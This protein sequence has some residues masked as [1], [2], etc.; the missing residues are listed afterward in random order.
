MSGQKIL[1]TAALPYANGPLHFG[2]IAGAYL[3]ADCYARFERLV[4]NKVLYICGSDEYGVAITLSAEK[5]NRSPKEHID[6]FHKINKDFFKELQISFDHYSRTTNEEHAALAQEFFLDLYN[7]GYIEEKVENHL[8]SEKDDKF[9]A[10][11]YV[12][13]TCPKC[14][15]EKARGDECGSCGASYEATDLKNPVSAISKS[16][17]ILKPSKHWY[18]RFDK[19][20]DKLKKWISKK[21]WKS[22]VMKFALNY[23]D[24]LKPRAIT[25]DSTWGVPVPLKDTEGKVLYVWF[26]AP[27]GYISATKEYAKK[28]NNEKLFD[29]FWLSDDTT[30]VNFIGKDNIPFHAIFFPAMQMGQNKKYKIVDQLPANEFLLLEKK[31][32]S[33]SNNWYIDLEE[34]FKKFST[35]Q[36]RFYLASIMPETS[37]SDFSWKDFQKV[38]NSDLVGKFGNFIHR[39]LTFT[40]N[41]L[42]SKIPQHNNLSNED[43]E[44][45]KNVDDLVDLSKTAYKN[46][47]LRKASHII[48]E[49]ASLGNVYFDKK[50]PWKETPDLQA[51]TIYCCI[52]AI[53]S[54]CLI[55]NPIIPTS[56]EKIWKLL[57]NENGFNSEKGCENFWDIIKNDKL[58]NREQKIN[59]P[60]TLFNKIED[61]EIIYQMDKLNKSA[62]AIKETTPALAS[63][64]ELKNKIKYDDFDKLDFRVGLITNAHKIEKSNKLLKLEVDIGIEKRT[65]VSGIAKFV[66]IEE[67][68]GKKVIVLANIEKT[69]IMGVESNGMIIAAGDKQDFDIPYLENTNIGSIVN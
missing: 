6:I 17:L 20:K 1:I 26:D 24:D 33:K 22:N 16:P 52:Y 58:D 49:L 40:K 36:L 9:L 12:E 25:R 65:I 2:H 3:P 13:G 62:E 51:N 38:C 11:R 15:F 67:L 14:G 68:L 4:G 35:D 69:T 59:D 34:F 46:F 43:N 18:L 19:F 45:L 31:Q 54:L 7:N 63:F 56:S 5:A 60:K 61:K 37:D 48:I 50:K 30:L 29:D 44:F 41:K 53:K 32:F 64:K 42:N 23:I 66:S 47:H 57:G 39:T 28:I 10:D 27:I 55:S 21:D 8:Y